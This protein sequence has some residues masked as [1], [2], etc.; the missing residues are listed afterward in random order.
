VRL[1]RGGSN[2]RQGRRERQH[3]P[4]LDRPGRQRPQRGHRVPP[5]RRGARKDR[6]DHLLGVAGRDPQEARQHLGLVL[7]REDSGQLADHR[8][9]QPPLAELRFHAGEARQQPRRGLPVPGGAVGESQLAGEEG[10]EAR[11][12]EP[13]PATAPIEVCQS[14]QEVR[15]RLALA[16]QQSG[17]VVPP[18]PGV[19]ERVGR[20]EVGE[21]T[22]FP[23]ADRLMGQERR[24]GGGGGTAGG[25]DGEGGVHAAI[26]TPES[27]ASPDAR[28]PRLRRLSGG[29]PR[30][31]RAI[32]KRRLLAV[33]RA[34]ACLLA[35]ASSPQRTAREVTSSA[36]VGCAVHRAYAPRPPGGAAPVAG[37]PW[38]TRDRS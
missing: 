20:D 17:E 34:P 4:R 25:I 7:R 9:T 1:G 23:G 29:G 13:L 18:G 38:P 11:V 37:R 21:A 12:P 35:T 3:G 6:R 16:A 22:G 10:E 36:Q 33:W 14:Q 31:P 8:Q 19:G 30:T 5:R 26:V 28:I 27:G 15:R 24:A 32:R 2:S